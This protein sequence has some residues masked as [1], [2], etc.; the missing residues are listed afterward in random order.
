MRNPTNGKPGRSGAFPAAP[1]RCMIRPGM[2]PSRLPAS[3]SSTPASD[4]GG[5]TEGHLLK[6]ARRGN[7]TAVEALFERCRSWLRPWARGR[8]PRWVRDGVDTSDVVNDALC[9]TFVRL[10]SFESNRASALR[11]YLQRAVE[12]RIHDQLRRAQRRSNT[13]IPD[14]A[15][16]VTGSG[17]SRRDRLFDEKGWREYRDGLG[18]LTARERRLIVGRVEMGCGYRQLAFLEGMSSADAARKA[19]GRAMRKLID[20]LD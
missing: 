7:R 3:S 16:W 13:S 17:R 20:I 6:Q 12:N 1:F 15:A 4:T 19:L 11:A 10:E 18:R 8:L 5:S 2:R 14:D 9:R